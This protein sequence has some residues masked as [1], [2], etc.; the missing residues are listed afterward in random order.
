MING[1]YSHLTLWTWNLHCTSLL[2]RYLNTIYDI[3]SNFLK[4]ISISS[5]IGSYFVLSNYL[6][7]SFLNPNLEYYLNEKQTIKKSKFR[8]WLR[9][10]L[11]NG[12]PQFFLYLNY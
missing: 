12:A 6:F 5:F 7:V 11:L 9:S 2:L 4:N 10:F 1:A 3:N 8:Y